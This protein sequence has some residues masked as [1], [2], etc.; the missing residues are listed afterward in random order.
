M[1][2]ARNYE[3]VHTMKVLLLKDVKNLGLRGE[4][5]EVKEGYFK[6]FLLP[7]KLAKAL[8][9]ALA[10]NLEEEKLRLKLQQEKE[11]SRLLKLKERLEGLMVEVP[12]KLGRE[13]QVFGSVSKTRILEQLGALGISLEKDQLLLQRPIKS[14]GEVAVPFDLGYEITGSFMVRVVPE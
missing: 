8:T 7:Q 11:K 10:R 12:T 6:N 3:F 14:T 2:N 1:N 9:Q 4:T 5:K 13:G